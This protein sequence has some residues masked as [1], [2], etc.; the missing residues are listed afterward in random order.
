M[1][2]EAWA[3]TSLGLY[4]RELLSI[5]GP[6]S[7]FSLGIPEVGAW[8]QWRFPSVWAPLHLKSTPSRDWRISQAV[9]GWGW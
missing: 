2:G 9:P 3:G 4:C 6:T 1:P 7:G 8:F 5:Q